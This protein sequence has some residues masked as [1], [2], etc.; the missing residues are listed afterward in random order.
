MSN[1]MEY[2]GYHAKIQFSE[3]D[4]VFFGRVIGINDVISFDG[5]SIQELKTAFREAID[6]YLAICKEQG[7]DPDKE[8]KGS[9]N[10]RISSDIHKAAALAAEAQ[11]ISMNRF[12]Q[13]AL[14]NELSGC[15]QQMIVRIV[16]PEQFAERYIPFTTQQSCDALFFDGQEVLTGC[17]LQA[18]YLNLGS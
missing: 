9:F 16:L 14:E 2:R 7:R 12:I 18:N 3:E 17:V 6:D 10:V 13:R 8:Y 15:H 4:D 5:K 1:L 11:S